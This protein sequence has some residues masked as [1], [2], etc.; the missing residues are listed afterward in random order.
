M[1]NWRSKHIE[2]GEI[3][4][5]KQTIIFQAI[6]TLPRI[7]DLSSS[8]GCSK[9]KFKRE[10]NQIVVT[11]TPTSIPRHLISQGWYETTKRI[12]VRYADGTQDVLLFSAKVIKN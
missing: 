11:Y 1:S 8:C 7:I 4:I 9:P 6:G 5:K 12:T 2:L 3:P 10:K